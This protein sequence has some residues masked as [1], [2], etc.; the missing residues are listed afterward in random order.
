MKNESNDMYRGILLYDRNHFSKMGSYAAKTSFQT[1]AW[2]NKVPHKYVCT[3]ISTTTFIPSMKSANTLGIS[4][5]YL[6]LSSLF[7][8][9][10]KRIKVVL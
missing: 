2:N 7:V 9:I 8:F 4:I 6:F 3:Y 10:I 1:C 5:T